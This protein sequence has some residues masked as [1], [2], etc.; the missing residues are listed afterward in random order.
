ML[1]VRGWQSAPGVD[2]VADCSGLYGVGVFV[3][4]CL[5]VGAACGMTITSSAA[6]ADLLRSGSALR[7]VAFGGEV[8]A[9]VSLVQL[10]VGTLVTWVACRAGCRPTR[11]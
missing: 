9:E 6:W 4:A 8:V 7:E 3:G 10:F 5:R 1:A 2:R 11:G